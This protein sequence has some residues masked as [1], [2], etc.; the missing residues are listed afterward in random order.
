[1]R[2]AIIFH[3]QMEDIKIIMLQQN[4]ITFSMHWWHTRLLLITLWCDVTD[5]EFPRVYI[6]L[7]YHSTVILQL[8]NGIGFKCDV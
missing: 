1:M 6:H 8:G 3:L 7:Q 2:N 5:F 4:T